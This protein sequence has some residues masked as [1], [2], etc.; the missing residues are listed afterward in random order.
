[1]PLVEPGYDPVL[2]G[3]R[4]RLIELESALADLRE[5]RRE[6]EATRPGLVPAGSTTWHSRAAAAYAER[7]EA[8][9]HAIANAER[10]LGDAEGTLAAEAERVRRTIQDPSPDDLSWLT[11][12]GGAGRWAT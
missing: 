4:R 10:L 12:D 8:I 2:I 6:V 7:R 5:L 3:R 9:R 11:G 1:M